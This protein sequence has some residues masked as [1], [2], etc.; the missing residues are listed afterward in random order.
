MQ[1]RTKPGRPARDEPPAPS[2]KRSVLVPSE[3]DAD[4]V[5]KAAARGITVHAAL[6]EAIVL[7]LV[8]EPPVTKA[9]LAEY[10]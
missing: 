8:T 7:W 1:I 5:A 6:R 3:H 9:I 10:E 2:R 4:L